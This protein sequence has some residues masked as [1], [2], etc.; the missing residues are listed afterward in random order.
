MIKLPIW[1][2]YF[3]Y[4]YKIL[5]VWKLVVL[6]FLFADPLVLRPLHFQKT[7]RALHHIRNGAFA[8]SFAVRCPFLHVR[9]TAIATGR[10]FVA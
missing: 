6:P 2:T 1:F 4:D 3:L 8:C 10:R 7:H 5:R 9:R